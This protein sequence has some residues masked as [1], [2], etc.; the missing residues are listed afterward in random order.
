MDTTRPDLAAL[1]RLEDPLGVLSVY[2]D[3]DPEGVTGARPAWAIEVDNR[4]GELREAIRRTEAHDRWTAVHAALDRLEPRIAALADPAAPGRGRALFAPLS[5]G[6]AEEL[7][8]QVPLATTVVLDRRAHLGPLLR[9]MDEARPTGVV[10]VSREAIRVVDL[11]MGAAE[12]VEEL[13]LDIDTST[14][15]RKAGTP[16]SNPAA[17]AAGGA[18]PGGGPSTGSMYQQSGTAQRDRFERK[19]ED[20]QVRFVAGAADDVLRIA[21]ERGWERM[22]VIGDPRLTGPLV[23]AVPET[24]PLEALAVEG[25]FEW[26]RPA[27][28]AEAIA[29]ALTEHHRRR[30]LEL[31]ERALA[32]AAAGGRGATGPEA[33]GA[34][35]VE[36][37]VEVLLIE[38]GRAIEG[39][40]AP[41]GRIAP[42]G[43]VPDGVRPEELEPEPR[44][45]ERMV[46]MALDASGRVVPVDGQAAA[47]LAEHG[48]VAAVLR[49]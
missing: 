29:P 35:L 2:V 26:Q 47:R 44:L 8:V 39:V 16:G 12:E 43:I 20:H 11:R 5:G 38:A 15:R 37:R 14:W 21:V 42:L 19:L 28:L 23:E 30:E 32:G 4:L 45:D 18:G 1:T 17:T 24:A 31:V 46:E 25:T 40:R 41:D 6:P 33:V 7:A 48:G 10:N 49:W 22:V 3:A 27:Q 13:E 34:A 9:A 36:G